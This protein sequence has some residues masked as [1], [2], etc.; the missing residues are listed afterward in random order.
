MLQAAIRHRTKLSVIQADLGKMNA[1]EAFISDFT[2]V[3]R[4]MSVAGA[5]LY[6]TQLVQP[7]LNA[8]Q[9]GHAGG[10]C[11]GAWD[12]IPGPHRPEMACGCHY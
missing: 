11:C 6:A 3:L 7:C 8:L 5:K 4:K 9:A 1:P 12:P 2:S 10:V